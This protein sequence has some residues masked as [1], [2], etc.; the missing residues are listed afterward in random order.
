V[1]VMPNPGNREGRDGHAGREQWGSLEG[2]WLS[3]VIPTIGNVA[4][5]VLWAFSAYGGW[6]I[7]AFCDGGPGSAA[8]CRAGFGATVAIS[9]PVAALGAALVLAAWTIPYVRRRPRRQL[10][11]LLIAALSWVLAEAVL[12]A[13]GW[14]A[15][16]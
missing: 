9:I 14:L 12:F 2:C 13:G 1:R 15:Q 8:G 16:S 6:G 5:A 4:L 7:T 11:G 3:P 10:L